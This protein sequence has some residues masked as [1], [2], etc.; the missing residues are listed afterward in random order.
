MRWSFLFICLLLCAPAMAHV[1]YVL[2]DEQFLENQG[3]DVNFLLSALTNPWYLALIGISVIVVLILGYVLP[4]KRFV[5][6]E[7]KYL[8]K[9]ASTYAEFIPW[10]GRLGLGIALIGA[11]SA[12]ILISPIEATT[13]LLS[14]IQIFV[15]FMLL[16]GLLTGIMAWLSV[17]LFFTGLMSNSYLFGNLDFLGLALSVIV[18]S[19]S[20]PGID[21]LFGIKFYLGVEKF[22]EYA[23]LLLRLG[24]GGAMVFLALYEKILNPHTSALVVELYN[25]QA[26]VPVSAAMWVLGAGVVELIIGVA[27][28]VGWKTRLM[29]GI[30]FLVLSLSFFYFNETVFSHITLFT[31]LSMLFVS[32]G[33]AK[34]V[35]ECKTTLKELQLVKLYKG[36][37]LH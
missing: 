4:T 23:P 32:G 3:S 24:I 6:D 19:Q 16:A 37:H 1:E 5:K 33:G 25:L 15:G 14:T 11:G 10:M 27:L 18:L 17:I 26:A 21:D 28:L 13:S 31:T 12:Q 8:K 35:D 34:S 7:V 2:E 22:K 30:A 36:Y 29:S 9:E 20:K